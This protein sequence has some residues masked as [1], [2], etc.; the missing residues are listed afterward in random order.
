MYPAKTA[1]A[2]PIPR[3][4]GRRSA[5]IVLPGTRCKTLLLHLR[6]C[7]GSGEQAAP[8]TVLKKGN[9]HIIMGN[10]ARDFLGLI[11]WM[12]FLKTFILDKL[13]FLLVLFYCI[14]S[15]FCAS[16]LQHRKR[17]FFCCPHSWLSLPFGC[18]AGVKIGGQVYS[19]F[20]SSG[21]SMRFNI[22]NKAF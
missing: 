10:C 12:I 13:P 4:L 16:A 11:R 14:F 18:F 9:F 5:Y 15:F 2:P 8:L 1:P 7:F 22:D 19:V 6:K 3:P 21:L 17:S 20:K